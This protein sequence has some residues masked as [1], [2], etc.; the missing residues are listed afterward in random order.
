M[1]VIRGNV[2]SAESIRILVSYQEC[3][4]NK[5][6]ACEQE[7]AQ[8]RESFK[9]QLLEELSVRYV[10]VMD[11][12]KSS[13]DIKDEMI[14]DMCGYPLKTRDSVWK[15]C[16][17]CKKGLLTRYGDLPSDFMSAEYTAERNYGGLLFSTV[18]FFKVIRLVEDILSDFFEEKDHVYVTN[19]Y[20]KVMSE[21]CK[22]KIINPCCKSHVESLPYLM[23]EYVQIRFHTESKRFRN[24]HLSKIR[25]DMNF[26]KKMS[27]TASHGKKNE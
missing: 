15:D 7:A 27:R 14:Y 8:L 17:E 18:N 24:L 13:D 12:P 3:L 20:E 22:L 25:T 11:D 26:N 10:T 9:E 23:M 1:Q 6:K 21:L 2:D 19:G 16:V 5:F 4:V